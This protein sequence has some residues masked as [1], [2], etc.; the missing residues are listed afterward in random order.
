MYF[1]KEK[2]TSFECFGPFLFINARFEY[3]STSTRTTI[4][5]SLGKYPISL[6]ML[7]KTGGFKFE[8]NQTT[9]EQVF[10]LKIKAFLRNICFI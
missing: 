9:A 1:A 2:Q 8:T 10:R 3:E 6:L 4:Q 7:K 5:I